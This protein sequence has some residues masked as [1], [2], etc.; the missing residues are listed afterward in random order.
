MKTTKTYVRKTYTSQ[1]LGR[2]GV[3]PHPVTQTAMYLYP[4]D[5]G[6]LARNHNSKR[7]E[8]YEWLVVTETVTPI[9]TIEWSGLVVEGR[10]MNKAARLRAKLEKS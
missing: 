5:V 4:E 10:A 3:T 8:V 7:D 2:G 6:E 9:S 1:L